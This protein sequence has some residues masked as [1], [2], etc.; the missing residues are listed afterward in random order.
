MTAYLAPQFSLAL[1]GPAPDIATIARHHI[2][3]AKTPVPNETNRHWRR[4]RAT[5]FDTRMFDLTRVGSCLWQDEDGVGLSC[6]QQ[7]NDAFSMASFYHRL[8]EKRQREDLPRI[9]SDDTSEWQAAPFA[10]APPPQSDIDPDLLTHILNDSKLPKDV[11]ALIRDTYTDFH[12]IGILVYDRFLAVVS[13]DQD[14]V[15]IEVNI[16]RAEETDI[17][18]YPPHQAMAGITLSLLSGEGSNLFDF[19]RRIIEESSGRIRIS[20]RA[21]FIPPFVQVSAMALEN[22]IK[23]GASPG[24]T[25]GDV[26]RSGIKASAINLAAATAVLCAASH[27]PF[28]DDLEDQKTSKPEVGKSLVRK[29]LAHNSL[30]RNS[31]LRSDAGR[32]ARVAMRRF[33]AFEKV[34][35][36][37][38]KDKGL[39]S[40]TDQAR[41]YAR[42][43]GAARDWDVFLHETLNDLA[44]LLDEVDPQGRGRLVLQRRGAAIRRARWQTAC[45]ALNDMKFAHFLL[46]LVEAGLVSPWRGDANADLI[47]P[48]EEFSCL[49]LDRAFLKAEKVGAAAHLDDMEAIHGLRLELKKFRYAAQ[50]FRGLYDKEERKPFFAALADLQERL[51]QLNDSVVAQ[52]LTTE[53]IGAAGRDGVAIAGYPSESDEA[54]LLHAA[55]F[56]AG[57][58]AAKADSAARAALP[59]WHMLATRHPYWRPQHRDNVTPLRIND[60]DDHA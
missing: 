23:A 46:D 35:R 32:R 43:I 22:P 15:R 8:D 44:P 1:E 33:R 57:A 37:A 6:R 38:I 39:R 45:A 10:N 34:Y 19:A 21:P 30:M 42:L 28:D 56:V 27:E 54:V 13:L 49:A 52:R 3:C 25:A 20:G 36:K 59:L 17:D 16:G 18:Q 29:S 9:M 2:L 26:L 5:Y 41:V 48:A 58:K 14:I 7:P 31:L 51:G 53:A 12:A 11:G 4:V 40:L 47:L 50:I 24:E 55:G 60:R